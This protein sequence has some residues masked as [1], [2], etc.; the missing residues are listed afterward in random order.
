MKHSGQKIQR[1]ACNKP[2]PV[3]DLAD[4]LLSQV[5]PN[6]NTNRNS[7]CWLRQSRVIDPHQLIPPSS[8]F[9][10]HIDRTRGCI[11][12]GG[13]NESVF[14]RVPVRVPAEPLVYR[15]VTLLLRE[16]QP[17]PLVTLAGWTY[18]RMLA[19]LLLILSYAA[20]SNI[21]AMQPP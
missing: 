18:R 21:Y 7:A 4:T 8:L 1:N 19:V 17:V 5:I 3:E 14:K 13:R 2:K 20:S 16:S 6:T 12:K 9:P 10:L 11:A 15:Q